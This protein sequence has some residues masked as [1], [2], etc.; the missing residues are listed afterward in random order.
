M[1]DQSG[2]PQC[3]YC[4][5]CTNQRA[6][7]LLHFRELIATSVEDQV[8]RLNTVSVDAPGVQRIQVELGL[9]SGYTQRLE[10]G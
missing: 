4:K 7:V 8:G 10:E 3:S 2:P 1:D 6:V 5:A 9:T